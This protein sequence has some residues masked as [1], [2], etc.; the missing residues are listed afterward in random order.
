MSTHNIRT[1]RRQRRRQRQLW[2]F[3][4]ALLDTRLPIGECRLLSQSQ[5]REIKTLLRPGD[6]LLESNSAYPIWQ[7]FSRLIVGSEWMHAAM[8]VGDGMV[9]DAGTEPKVA[10]VPIDDFLNTTDIVIY[11]PDFAGPEDVAA[12]ITFVEKQ[13]GMPFNVGFEENDKKSFYCTQLVS[14]AL[15][16]MPHPIVLSMSRIFWKTVVTPTAITSSAQ[17]KLIWASRTRERVLLPESFARG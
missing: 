17:I 3:L 16:D 5:R 14:R 6:V 7:L 10:R 11:R 2:T 12:A 8:Y 1:A 15:F 4:L 9:I 13:L